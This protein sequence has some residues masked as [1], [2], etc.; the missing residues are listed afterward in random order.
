MS[1]GNNSFDNDERK[2]K[3]V[4][5]TNITKKATTCAMALMLLPGAPALTDCSGKKAD[6]KN[7]GKVTEKADQKKTEKD[8]KKA[9][10]NKKAADSKKAADN[11][12][13]DQKKTDNYS[14]HNGLF[15]LLFLKD[16]HK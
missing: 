15:V 10:D 13:T 6:A 12:K 14:F 4:K 5:K 2:Y 11:K 1:K 3:M 8:N 16:L 9:S 7:S